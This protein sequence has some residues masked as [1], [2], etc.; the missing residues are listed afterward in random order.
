MNTRLARLLSTAALLVVG[1]VAFRRATATTEAPVA[2][3]TWHP[4]D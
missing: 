2:P 3:G 4:V 1:L